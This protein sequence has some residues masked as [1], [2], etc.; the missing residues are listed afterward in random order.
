MHQENDENIFFN[1]LNFLTMKTLK[2]KSILFSLL[3]IMAVTVFMTSCGQEELVQTLISDHEKAAEV[4]D[5]YVVEQADGTFTLSETDPHTLG[6]EPQVLENLISSFN[7]TNVLIQKDEIKPEWI[8]K[9]FDIQTMEEIA[10]SD[11]GCNEDKVEFT[12]YG[13]KLYMSQELARDAAVT[14][15]IYGGG[16]AAAACELLI[17]FANNYVCHCGYINHYFWTGYPTWTTCQ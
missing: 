6:I 8:G 1:I 5:N 14:G 11:R 16:I 12:W 2:V 4:L 3:A 17:I 7:E 10:L 15:C 13:I 9:T